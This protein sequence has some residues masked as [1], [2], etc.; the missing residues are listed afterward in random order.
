MLFTVVIGHQ[1]HAVQGDIALDVVEVSHD[2]DSPGPR[3]GGWFVCAHGSEDS[4]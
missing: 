2:R 3:D 4:C 1:L